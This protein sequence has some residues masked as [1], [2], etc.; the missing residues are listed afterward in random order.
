MAN[1]EILV[2]EFPSLEEIIGRLK[3][4]EAEL[5]SLKISDA[6]YDSQVASIRSKLKNPA[7]VD[8]VE[9]ELEDLR[10]Q[11]GS[12]D[13]PPELDSLYYEALF[14]GEGQFGKVFRVRR[15]SDDIEVAVKIPVSRDPIIGETFVAEMTLWQN[16]N[17]LNIVK[18]NKSNINPVPFLEMELCK[19]NLEDLPKPLETERA[20]KIVLD[21]AEGLKYAHS[22]DITHR[23]LKPANILLIDG[24][25]KIMDWGFSKMMGQGK[26]SMF[27]KFTPLYAAP[28]QLSSEA[29]GDTDKR[30]DIYQLGTIFYELVTKWTPFRGDNFSEVMGQIISAQPKP[31][32]EYNPDATA[33][34]PIIMKCLEKDK[35]ERYQTI[36][37]LQKDLADYLNIEYQE[38]LKESKGDMKRSGYYCA[39]LCMV[40][41]QTGNIAGAI[42]YAVDLR[43]YATGEAKAMLT[44]L[45]EELDFHRE[46]DI[47]VSEELVERASI[48]VHQVKM[49]R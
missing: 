20:T 22:K 4:A 1:R 13:F 2:R 29:F 30:T 44:K 3:Q 37:E 16:L 27:S 47:P 38:L 8:E 14:I 21:I 36:E 25:P 34:E 17:H 48:L 49:G 43:N 42:K 45:I 35:D 9:K 32:S 40:H 31:P 11:L 10:K 39:E 12:Q 33:V 5:D 46:K 24:V 18:L 23:D 41:L 15:R 6:K 19:D 7:K 28:E 26:K